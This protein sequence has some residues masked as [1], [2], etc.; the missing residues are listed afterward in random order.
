M[1]KEH[2]VTIAGVARSYASEAGFRFPSR[3]TRLQNLLQPSSGRRK[4]P[5][6]CGATVDAQALHR[7]AAYWSVARRIRLV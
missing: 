7:R 1:R 4:A 5:L 3:W 2:E 6:H